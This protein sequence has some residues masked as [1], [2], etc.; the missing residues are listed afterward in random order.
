[1]AHLV[2]RIAP[3]LLASLVTTLA[4][5]STHAE[6]PAAPDCLAKPNGPAAKGSHWYYRIAHPSGRHCWYQRPI[7]AAKSAPA[8]PQQP[9][10]VAAPARP[11]APA[12][13]PASQLASQAASPPASDTST[14]AP[15]ADADDGQSVVPPTSA[16]AAATWPAVAAPPAVQPATPPSEP[17]IAEPQPTS[18]AVPAHIPVRTLKVERPA[19]KVERTAEPA[20]TT[21]HVPALLGAAFALVIIVLGL[22]AMRLAPQLLR[23]PAAVPL[24]DLRTSIIPMA[25]APGIV[26]AMPGRGDGERRI[27]TPRLPREDVSAWRP[28]EPR[29]AEP[30]PSRE[31][32]RELEENVRELL[33]RLQA[34]LRARPDDTPAPATHAPSTQEL[35]A[36]LAMWRA[37]RR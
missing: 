9:A 19:E 20:E 13:Q 11:A 4:T 15:A 6:T 26:P 12:S 2:T 30:T 16:P 23:R 31:T 25:D 22:L 24:R 34:D 8:A 1:M 36:V 7:D 33:R 27:R 21:N 29:L 32:A 10:A 3:V 37:K 17:K 18:L 35:D 14:V 5:V 28:D